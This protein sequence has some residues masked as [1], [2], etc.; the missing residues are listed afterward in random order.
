MPT[1]T[2]S[3]GKDQLPEKDATAP[4]TAMDARAMAM[5]PYCPVFSCSWL[6]PSSFSKRSKILSALPGSSFSYWRNVSGG[7]RGGLAWKE[8]YVSLRNSALISGDDVSSGGSTSAA[9]TARFLSS[10]AA[11]EGAG[12]SDA[13]SLVLCADFSAEFSCCSLI[14]CAT[15]LLFQYGDVIEQRAPQG[16]TDSMVG[17]ADALPRVIVSAGGIQRKSAH[18]S[19]QIRV[20]QHF[21]TF[22]LVMDGLWWREI[23]SVLHGKAR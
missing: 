22:C 16:G 12:V 7:G 1:K 23:Y 6:R 2:S 10:P 9:A 17:R 8:S 20:F 13:E 19:P 4:A 11:S 18:I 15:G 5:P 3:K 21:H 14:L